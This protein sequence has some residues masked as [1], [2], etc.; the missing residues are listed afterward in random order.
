MHKLVLIFQQFSL[1]K[2]LDTFIYPLNI[3]T[4]LNASRETLTHIR[5]PVA[6]D[7]TAPNESLIR[8]FTLRFPHFSM[9]QLGGWNTMTPAGTALAT[10]LVAHP[11]IDHLDLGFL[12]QEMHCHVPIDFLLGP[13]TLPNLR[14]LT[15]DASNLGIFVR[16][17]MSSLQTLESLHIGVRYVDEQIDD[18]GFAEMY[19]ALEAYGGLQGLK[20]LEL[21]LEGLVNELEIARWIS[22]FGK[23][24]PNVEEF[25][26]DYKVGVA[27]VS[28]FVGHY[29]R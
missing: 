7:Y 27:A 1:T 6:I 23:L 29:P 22:G 11:L 13:N 20:V 4:P 19:Q 8:F 3:F 16:S 15:V 2:P 24:C 18:V 25:W 5:I 28:H 9:L 17:G 10:F 12:D 26:G 14:Y 21:E